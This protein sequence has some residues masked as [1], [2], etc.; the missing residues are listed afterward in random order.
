MQSPF[1]IFP[2]PLL[3]LLIFKRLFQNA[4]W[5]K[6]RQNKLSPDLF[7]P[8]W[9]FV[10][11]R[12]LV[13]Q[14]GAP[15]RRK[16]PVG[17]GEEEEEEEDGR[18]VRASSRCHWLLRRY[19]SREMAFFLNRH[20]EQQQQQQAEEEETP[21][22]WDIETRGHTHCFSTL[23][24]TSRICTVHSMKDRR[25]GPVSSLKSGMDPSQSVKCKIVVVGD[26]QCGK[27]ALLHVFAKDCFPEVRHLHMD[28]SG[29]EDTKLS[30][31]LR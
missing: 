23:T 18:E 17:C 16:T 4:S 20:T 26:S 10:F 19:K 14:T 29:P 31:C 3:L 25:C 7:S 27:T 28:G 15:S 5:T 30:T 24:N 6:N 12:K 1:W 21:E 13:V 11:T 8:V 9:Q 2:H 22:D